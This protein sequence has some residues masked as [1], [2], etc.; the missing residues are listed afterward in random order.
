[1][2]C[3]VIH[4]SV[5]GRMARSISNQAAVAKQLLEAAQFLTFTPSAAARV[6]AA[7]PGQV[8]NLKRL[9]VRGNLLF[10]EV[11]PTLIALPGLIVLRVCEV[12]Q[13][14][15]DIAGAVGEGLAVGTQALIDAVAATG[16]AFG[17]VVKGLF[18]GCGKSS[19]ASG[20]TAGSPTAVILAS[21]DPRRWR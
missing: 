16:G 10:L 13:L 5:S 12:N 4:G 2:V 18:G 15:C 21:A 7:V 20:G 8:R 1:M 17:S 3:I 19:A 11:P 9:G 14:A 6:T